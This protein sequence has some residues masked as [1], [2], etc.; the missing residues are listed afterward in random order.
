M[1][2]IKTHGA[3]N[4]AAQNKVD[5]YLSGLYPYAEADNNP[6]TWWKVLILSCLSC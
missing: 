6:L 2:A 5:V 3:A 4:R 1:A